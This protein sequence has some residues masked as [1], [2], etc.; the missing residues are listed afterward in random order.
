M[1]TESKFH[2]ESSEHMQI[3]NLGLN[4]NLKPMIATPRAQGL[5][6]NDRD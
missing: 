1:N 6:G 5:G 3:R 2:E 4:L